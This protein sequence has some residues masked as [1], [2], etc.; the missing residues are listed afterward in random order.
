MSKFHLRDTVPGAISAPAEARVTERKSVGRLGV[1]RDIIPLA[2]VE[3]AST[4]LRSFRHVAIPERDEEGNLTGFV[5]EV[6]PGY[7][8]GPVRQ[9]KR[10]SVSVTDPNSVVTK[11]GEVWVNYEG[12]AVRTTDMGDTKGVPGIRR[13]K[14]AEKAP[15]RG[16]VKSEGQARK[17]RALAGRS[18]DEDLAAFMVARGL[19]VEKLAD[20]RVRAAVRD[21]L[22]HEASVAAYIQGR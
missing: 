11:I 3:F 12:K 1:M 15:S 20:K 22:A 10:P 21:M 16:K 19:P 8:V 9:A 4:Q 2:P 14:A 18:T 7:E 17:E 5:A 13:P 6:R